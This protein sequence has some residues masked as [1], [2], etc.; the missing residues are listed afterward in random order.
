MAARQRR[1]KNANGTG[2][3]YY[4]EDGRWE[5]KTFVD[6]PDG[7]RK[8]ISVY[9]G[10]EREVLDELGKLR[11]QQRRGIPVATTTMTVAEYTTYWL[12]QVAEPAIR[13][14]TYAT[15]EGDV[16]LHIVP[17]IGKRK[18]KTLQ[19]NDIRTWLTRLRTLC[20]CCAQGKDAGRKEPRCCAMDQPKCCEDV[21]SS[22]SIRHIL[23]VLRAALQD[24]VDEELL[25]RNVARLVQL[26]VTDDRKVRSFTRDE[27]LRFLRAAEDHRL[28]ALW[29]VAL[30]MGLRRGEALGLAWADIDLEKAQLTVRQA[31]HRVDGKLKLDRVKTEASVATLPIPVP[32]VAILREHRE[33]QLEERFT[34]GS[35]WRDTGL[36]F[37]TAAG[38]YVE[39]RNV[40]RLFHQLCETAGVRQLRV[41]DLR[42]SC[43]TLLFTMGVPPA[44]VQ[45]IL[46]HSS[47]SVTTNT[48]VEVIEAVQRD[49]LDAMADL[50]THAGEGQVPAPLSSRGLPLSS[51]LSSEAAN[52][53]TETAIDPGGAK[54]IRT[55]DPH[56]ASVVRYQ[57]RHS[58]MK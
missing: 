50:F 3:V 30:A 39:P 1:K 34:A 54:G 22:S 26:R 23:R 47:I 40:N 52:E 25:S 37:T 21:L 43:A 11:D 53:V 17:G 36:V 10:T 41:H 18:L 58:P 24:A 46:R 38:G 51:T 28:Y 16:R 55:P 44:T 35:Q 32:L 57:L 12:E 4:R 14:T 15:Y 9:G 8:R 48:Y 56:T 19:A 42:H 31:L 5:A 7:R 6:T 33:R 29:A 27:A 45:R 13:R 2:G 49:A 20:Q